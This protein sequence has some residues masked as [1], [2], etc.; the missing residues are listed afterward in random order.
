M[1]NAK[2]ALRKLFSNT[3]GGNSSAVMAM[4][5]LFRIVNL[6]LA[7][8][9]I[10][11][12]SKWFSASEYIL[13]EK[14]TFFLMIGNI[15]LSPI[16]VS[17][18]HEN[19]VDHMV[20]EGLLLLIVLSIFVSFLLFV[21]TRN[22]LLTV[23]AS[24]VLYFFCYYLKAT[25]YTHL[26]TLKRYN[27]AYGTNT[28]FYLVYILVFALFTLGAYVHTYL[29]SFL[30][31]PSFILIVIFLIRWKTLLSKEKGAPSRPE[32]K[33][34]GD[35]FSVAL[36]AHSFLTLLLGSAERFILEGYSAINEELL[37]AFLYLATIISAFQSLGI[38]LGE[39]LRPQVFERMAR[40]ERV[41]DLY[42]SATS[43]LAIIFAVF[44]IA[45]WPVLQFISTEK[46][47]YFTFFPYFSMLALSQLLLVLTFFIDL[48]IVYKKRYI[49]L[50][51]ASS[52]AIAGK[53]LGYFIWDGFNELSGVVFANVL[54]AS[55]FF[56]SMVFFVYT[57]NSR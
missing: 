40:G 41:S 24:S 15:L 54:G 26:I 53:A 20:T 17:M 47:Q 34:L 33:K 50:L 36:L 21:S 45:G 49:L 16:L 7:Y 43:M 55:I 44:L 5:L 31:L 57:S 3:D 32:K 13:F 14:I 28:L 46:T 51:A 39:W 8:S 11:I 9:L 1:N 22:I 42:K 48:Q 2:Q 10:I 37:A 6:G 52:L 23:A 29:L 56:G 18:W 12:I 4:L 19:T 35:V 38:S 27:L 30:L 25:L